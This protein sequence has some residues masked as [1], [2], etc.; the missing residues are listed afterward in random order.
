MPTAG[1]LALLIASIAVFV[2]GGVISLSRLRDDR[3][4]RRLAAKVC[5]YFGTVLGIGLLAWHGATRPNWAPLDDNFD[6]LVW[7]AI[8]LSLFVAYTQRAHPLRGLDF[9]VMPI[10]VLLLMLA[11]VF[12]RTKPHSYAETPWMLVH[13]ISAYGGFAAFAVAAAVGT[14]YL[15]ANTRLRQKRAMPGGGFGSLE[16]LE[17]LSFTAVTL[18]FALLTIGLVTGLVRAIDSHGNNLLGPDWYRKPKV[19]LAFGAWI[20]YALVLHSPI[21]PSFRGRRAAMLSVLGFFLMIGTLVA[22]QYVG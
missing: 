8:L 14:M 10:V 2:L 13:R 18:G 7:L 15:I 19:L 6:A 4:P 22:V 16:R 12:G 20:V 21:N 11:A 3:G 1:Q 17:N 9:F 5:L